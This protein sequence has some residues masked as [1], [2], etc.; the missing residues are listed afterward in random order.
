MRIHGVLPALLTP[1]DSE[2]LVSEEM[3]RR[4]V[5]L[6]IQ[7]GVSGLYIC[8]GAGEGVLLNVAERKLVTEIVVREA[9]KRIPVIVHVGSV[10]TE[11]AAQLAAHAEKVGADVIASVPPF[12]YPCGTEAIHQHYAEI[13]RRCGL[14]LMLYNIPA[15]TGVTVTPDMM[16]RFMDIPTVVG[17]KFSSNDLFQM[18]QIVELGQGLNVLSGNDEI[19]LAALCMGAHGSIGLTLNF[20]PKLFMDIFNSFQAGDIEKAQKSQFLACRIIAVLSRYSVIPAAKEIMTWRGFNCGRARGPLENLTEEQKKSLR[21]NLD[22]LGFF[23]TALG[24]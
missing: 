14:P 23:E 8:G 16:L 13:A 3:L 22:Q 24:L 20:M 15:L 5:A 2:G 6:H 18:R 17:M 1:Y 11:D 4:L 12:F 21:R 10:R 9:R 7:L 19:F